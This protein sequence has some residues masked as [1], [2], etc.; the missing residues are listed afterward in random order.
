MKWLLSMAGIF[1]AIGVVWGG[2]WAA[3]EA[4]A[5]RPVLKYELQATMA[6]VEQTSKTVLLL[7]FQVLDAKLK[8]NGRL[9]FG[10]LQQYCAVA[11]AL[12]FVQIPECH[13]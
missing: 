7:Q 13:L 9:E 5:L 10:E 12:G 4:T 2:L 3:G 8:Q 11:R 1:T 6:Q